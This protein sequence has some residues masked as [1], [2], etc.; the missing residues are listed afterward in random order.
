MR[1]INSFARVAL[2]MA[3]LGMVLI[4]GGCPKH[5]NFPTPLDVVEA[6]A[7]SDFVITSQGLSGTG[8]YDYDLSWTVSD[9]THV[10][11]YRLYLVDAGFTPELVQETSANFLPISLPFNAEGLH[12]GLSTVSDGSVESAMTIAT[13]PPVEAP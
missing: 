13:I 12:F 5:E 4:L 1:G 8:T 11:R 9:A 2:I 7:P 3:A 10:D 6:P